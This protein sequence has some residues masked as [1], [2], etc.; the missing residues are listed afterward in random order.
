MVSLPIEKH[1]TFNM[2]D[3]NKTKLIQL[4][5]TEADHARL[6][7]AAGDMTLSAYM[8]AVIFDKE[9]RK[10]RV[11]RKPLKDEQALS[12]ALNLLMRSQIAPNLNQIAKAVHCGMVL[13]PDEAIEA[14]TCAQQE[15]S[16]TRTLL[17]KSLGKKA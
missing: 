15:L 13:M 6:L 14:L 2:S 9:L 16:T 1:T 17:L 11:N 4:R 5:I 7:D 10:V 12:Q 3:N 8:R